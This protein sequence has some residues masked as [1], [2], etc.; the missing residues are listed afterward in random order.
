M[1]EILVRIENINC[2]THICYNCQFCSSHEEYC[3]LF[4]TKL[5]VDTIK[6]T[7]YDRDQLL[8]CDECLAGE[9]MINEMKYGKRYKL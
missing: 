5:E 8:R 3:D 7:N 1:V 6:D 4:G 9:R 2:N